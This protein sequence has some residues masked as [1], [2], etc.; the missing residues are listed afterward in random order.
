MKIIITT[1]AL[2]LAMLLSGCN[3]KPPACGDEKAVASIKN[4][5]AN[6]INKNLISDESYQSDPKPVANFFKTLKFTVNT[7][8][9]DGYDEQAKRYSCHSKLDVEFLDKEGHFNIDYTTQTTEDKKDDFVITVGNGKS[10]IAE[11]SRYGLDYSLKNHFAGTWTGTYSCEG[12]DGDQIGNKAGFAQPV[13]LVIQNYGESSLERLTRSGGVEKL[14]GK[15]NRDNELEL[16]GIGKNSP[17]DQWMAY[18]KGP[19]KGSSI[20]SPGKIM[21]QTGERVF[22]VCQLHLTRADEKTPASV[23][24]QTP[25]G[26]KPS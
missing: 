12:M 4:L 1:L 15:I 7:I 26:S 18:F 25:A 23:Q 2:G 17:D 6:E 14:R 9:S 10:I 11:I 20:D 5:L 8:T 13:S 16:A 19:V 21:D 3:T 22:R 24:P